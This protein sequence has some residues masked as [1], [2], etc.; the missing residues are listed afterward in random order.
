MIKKSLKFD[1]KDYLENPPMIKNLIEEKKIAAGGNDDLKK[2]NKFLI[3]R[4][5]Q[6][7]LTNQKLSMLL[8]GNKKYSWISF[9]LSLF[10][11]VL[12]GIGVN[13]VTNDLQYKAGVMLIVTSCVMEVLVFFITSKIRK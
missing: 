13:C 10:A 11:M 9:T 12:M 1:V 3:S 5:H 6:L 7:E 8:E 4:V 2:E